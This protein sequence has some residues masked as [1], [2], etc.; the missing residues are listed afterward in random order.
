MNARETIRLLCLAGL[1]LLGGGGNGCSTAPAPASGKPSSAGAFGR[2]MKDEVNRTST[3]ISYQIFHNRQASNDERFRLMIEASTA[4]QSFAERI[5]KYKPP[6]HSE[7]TQDYEEF[8]VT[9]RHYA[10]GL[11]ESAIERNMDQAVMWFWHVKNT[12][13]TCHQIYRFGEESPMR[14]TSH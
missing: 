14:G 8:A 5:L 11:R 12:C 2:F 3:Q 7:R 13:A 4:L 9:L 6:L 1:S 10:S